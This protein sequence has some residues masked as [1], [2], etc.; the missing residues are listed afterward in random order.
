[1]PHTKCL[2]VKT[3][4]EEQ[5]I[6]KFVVFVHVLNQNTIVLKISSSRKQLNAKTHDK[7]YRAGKLDIYYRNRK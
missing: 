4:P 2:H 5:P 3:G 6:S 7:Y 1:M